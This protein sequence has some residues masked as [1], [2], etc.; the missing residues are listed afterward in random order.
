MEFDVENS[1]L[2]RVG[3][4]NVVFGVGIDSVVFGVGM[5]SGV[6]DSNL[7]PGPSTSFANGNHL[8]DSQP[9]EFLKILNMLETHLLENLQDGCY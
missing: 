2:Q 7:Q 1:N 4:D 8:E 3:I 6:S 9:D 5:D